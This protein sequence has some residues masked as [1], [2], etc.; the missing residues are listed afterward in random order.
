MRISEEERKKIIEVLGPFFAKAAGKLFLI[1]SRVNDCARGGDIDFLILVKKKEMES[2]MLAKRHI[3]LARLKEK[4]GDQ[5]IDITVCVNDQKNSLP[6]LESVL[7][8]A[9]LLGNWD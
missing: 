6:F 5:K 1:G 4:L 3:I 2:R 9:V 8:D 7:E